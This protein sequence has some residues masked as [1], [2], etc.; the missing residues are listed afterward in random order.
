M[1]H[2]CVYFN[3]TVVIMDAIEA[4]I[5]RVLP[6]LSGDVLSAVLQCLSDCGVSS[7]EDLQYL[8]ERD[9]ATCLKPI[10]IRK[11][12]ACSKSTGNHAMFLNINCY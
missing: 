7:V 9:L 1:P 6:L 10:Q 5:T 2:H 11:L 3:E 4:V 8:E 12:I